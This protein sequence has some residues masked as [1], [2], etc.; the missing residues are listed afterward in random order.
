MTSYLAEDS[1]R[2]NP[3]SSCGPHITQTPVRAVLSVVS[4]HWNVNRSTTSCDPFSPRITWFSIVISQC[5]WFNPFIAYNS[6][7]YH[8]IRHCN[9]VVINL[10][11]H[12]ILHTEYKGCSRA[13]LTGDAQTYRF[14]D[15]SVNAPHVCVLASEDL[16]DVVKHVMR[17]RV[18]SHCCLGDDWL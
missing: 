7:E 2:T 8:V 9:G 16:R 15:G 11:H 18:Y 5:W 6:S 13:D 4:D 1:D 12:M 14:K 3:N 10:L 17:H